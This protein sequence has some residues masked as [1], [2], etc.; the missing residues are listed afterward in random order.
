MNEL[1]RAAGK[2]ARRGVVPSRKRGEKILQALLDMGYTLNRPGPEISPDDEEYSVVCARLKEA[3]SWSLQRLRRFFEH[4]NR[5]LWD[6]CPELYLRAGKAVLRRSEPLLAYDIF[7]TGLKAMGGTFRLD[8]LETESTPVAIELIRNQAVALA[9]SSAPSSAENLLKQLVEQH[10]TDSETMGLLGRVYKDMAFAQP[11]RKSYYLRRAY[12]TYFRAYGRAAREYDPEGAYYNGINTATLAFLTG[13]RLQ[14]KK[15]ATDV[16]QLCL[17]LSRKAGASG[18]SFWLD[19]T[20]GEAALLQG[21]LD[22]AE[23]YY[24]QACRKAGQDLV[25]LSSIIRQ[26]RLI[27]AHG[28]RKNNVKRAPSCLLPS[29]IVFSG[30]MIDALSRKEARFPSS[31]QEEIGEKI[32]LEIARLRGG[33]GYSAAAA[34]SD[35]LFLEAMLAAGGK[36]HVVLPVDIENFKEQSLRPSGR[37]WEERFEAVVDKAESLTVLDVFN[38][39]NFENSLEFTNRYLFGIARMRAEQMQTSLRP[40]AVLQENDPGGRGGTAGMVRLWQRQ[41]VEYSLISLQGV[42]TGNAP[43]S[44]FPAPQP[45]SW[46]CAEKAE[47]HTSLPMLF[48]DVRGY[49]RLTED[50][51]VCFSGSFLAR[52]AEILHRF[53]SSIL[54][55]RTAGDGLFLVFHDL[56]SAIRVARRLQKMISSHDWQLDH[57][58]PNLQMRISL[59]A[60]PCYSYRDPIM[61][62]LEFCGNYVVRAARIEP[63]TPPGHIYASDTFVALCRAEGL[64]RGDFSYA[65]QVVLPKGFGTLAVFHVTA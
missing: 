27:I 20:L 41:Q 46:S 35:I 52:V 62:K 58:P 22:R 6:Q 32:R 45:G 37:D 26:A 38:P 8:Q 25:A 65:G 13:D 29:V 12:G 1:G 53:D 5:W 39:G 4:R 15:I 33:V 40:L 60:G 44:V 17:S 18:T 21:D 36:V 14:A 56:E 64:G 2:L 57:L 50:E 3:D 28:E 42:G 55:K 51:A 54:S 9:R 47:H 30:H 34:G 23:K 7:S 24:E 59:D 43:V 63:I 31:K 61:N 48:A 11:G 16:E 10:V 19:A 49:S